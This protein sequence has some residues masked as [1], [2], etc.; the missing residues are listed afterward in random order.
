MDIQGVRPSPGPQEALAAIVESSDDA[1]IGKTLDGTIT[2]WNKAAE[3]LYGY[4]SEEA[5]GQSIALIVPSDRGDELPGIMA[6]LQRGE[7]IEPFETVRQAKDGRRIPVSLSV[8]PIRDAAGRVVGAASIGRDLTERKQAEAALRASEQQAIDILESIG[9]GFY[10]LDAEERLTY[11]N[12]RTEQLWGRRCEDLVG[13]RLWEL[14]PEAVGTRSHQEHQRAARERRPVEYQTFSPIIGRWIEVNIYP[15]VTGTTVYFRDID[16][17]KQAEDAAAEAVRVRDDVL[18]AVSH[19]LRNPLAA[20]KGQAQILER[21]ALR[22]DLPES[23]LLVRGLRQIDAAAMRMTAWIEELLDVTQLQLGQQLALQPTDTDLA[24]LL[25]QAVADHQQIAHR[26]RLHLNEPEVPLVGAYDA[27]RLRR[28]FDN[29]LSNAVKYSPEGGEITVSLAH[30][31]DSEG[32]W[33]AVRVRDPG[34]GIPVADQSR[35][36]ERFHRAGNVASHFIGTGLG[37]AGSFAI[38]QQHGGSITVDSRERQG[39]TFTVRLPLRAPSR[40]LV[41]VA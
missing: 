20:I 12:R 11:I 35:I 19:D 41:C 8:S 27:A 39:S 28:V 32:A 9:D 30:E 31:V 5:I 21:W 24:E 29:L 37:L 22:R 14:F 7:K 1:I 34:V 6:R 10:A 3:R 25:R 40:R 4:T 18:R 13:K 33:A 26:H 15:S 16:A 36:F 2:S 23:E 17:R 38:V